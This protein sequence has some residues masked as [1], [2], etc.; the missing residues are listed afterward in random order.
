MA[1]VLISQCYR[2]DKISHLTAPIKKRKLEYY[3][4]LL[5]AYFSFLSP[6][7]FQSLLKQN[8]DVLNLLEGFTPLL[9]ALLPK[10]ISFDSMFMEAFLT[11]FEMAYVKTV[12]CEKLSLINLINANFSRPDQM[13]NLSQTISDTNYFDDKL[14]TRERQAY[15]SSYKKA[16]FNLQ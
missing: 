15:I 1:G 10:N 9:N 6:V 8:D 4:Q 2:G 14:Q 3:S 12:I 7:S 16:F 11:D 5:E 13:K